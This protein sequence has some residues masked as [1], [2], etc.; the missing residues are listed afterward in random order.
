MLKLRI[1]HKGLIFLLVPLALQIVC[2]FQLFQLMNKIERLSLNEARMGKIMEVEDAIIM[3]FAEGW[4]RVLSLY[5]AGDDPG[6]FPER[7]KAD[8]SRLL[9][10]ARA[11]LRDSDE[12]QKT[13]AETEKFSLDEYEVMKELRDQSR[14]RGAPSSELDFILRLKPALSKLQRQVKE[15]KVVRQR[16][17]KMRE[18]VQAARDKE[19][20]ARAEL[21]TQLIIGIFADVALTIALLL[22]FLRNISN[23]LKIVVA[24]AQLIPTG[25]PL[26]VK[27][28]GTD[29]LAYLDEVLHSAADQ[30]HEAAEHK[31][32][33]TEMVAHDLRGPLASA[34]LMVDRLIKQYSTAGDGTAQASGGGAGTGGNTAS[35]GGVATLKRLQLTMAQLMGLAE[36]L[37][38]VDKL[39]AGKLEL[40]IDVVDVRSLIAEVVDALSGLSDEKQIQVISHVGPAT[41]VGDRFRLYQVLSNLL[42]NAIKFSPP[43]SRV[44]MAVEERA[45]DVLFSVDDS[46]PGIDPAERTQIFEKFYKAKA[47]SNRNRGFG[48]GLAICKL[49]VLEHKGKIGV[50]STG[51]GSTFWFTLPGAGEEEYDEG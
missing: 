4:A 34:R 39:E 3:R 41:V 47:E 19:I 43:H 44:V 33:V 20:D 25:K 11:L 48:L 22:F 46:G 12:D 7:Y 18:R 29:E 42:S 49:I 27:V 35:G 6:D 21:K 17:E 1:L 37:L 8:I 23:R 24:N 45:G 9:E 32:M 38:T 14:D 2:I 28:S 36:D 10:S 31:A 50:S 30:L 26:T 16:I 13:F 15:Q 40:K 51:S 5:T